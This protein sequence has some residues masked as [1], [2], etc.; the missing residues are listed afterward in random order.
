MQFT[1]GYLFGMALQTVPE[2]RKVARDLFD[3]GLSRETLWTALLLMVVLATGLSVIAD[4]LFPIDAQLMGPVLSNPILLGVVEGAFMFAL[5]TAIYV[6][7]RLMGGQGSL[8]NAIMTVVWMEF[9]FLG[10]Q[11]LTVILSLIAPAMAALLMF[12]SVFLFFWVLSHFTAEN[13]GFQ[14]IGLV[15]TSILIF[16]VLAVF[17][18]SFI[19][20]LLGV[21][22][23]ELP[24]Q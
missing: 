17:A 4:V 9:I 15:F 18:L 20:V 14:S 7:G 1:P 10:L 16:M 19:L 8:E 24:A 11:V 13:H 2:P 5:S 23:I 3:L 21:E 6:I 12:A 22:P